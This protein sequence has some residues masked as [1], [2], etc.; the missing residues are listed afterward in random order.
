VLS[1]L[2]TY[3]QVIHEKGATERARGSV[4]VRI[5][6]E[7]AG[8]RGL[9]ASRQKA[10]RSGL[11]GLGLVVHKLWKKHEFPVTQAVGILEIRLPDTEIRPFQGFKH[12]LAGDA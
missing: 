4:N 12:R 2:P 10:G 9:I 5:F 11:L 3:L 6:W 7:Y 1:G 8:R